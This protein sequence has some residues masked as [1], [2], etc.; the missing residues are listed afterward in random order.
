MTHLCVCLRRGGEL[1]MEILK[2]KNLFKIYIYCV[3]TV[4]GGN[5][6]ILRPNFQFQANMVILLIFEWLES[7]VAWGNSPDF[8]TVFSEL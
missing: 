2:S 1:W 8:H 3:E 7:I 6:I 5:T 4:K